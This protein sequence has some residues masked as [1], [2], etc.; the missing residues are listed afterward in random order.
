[1]FGLTLVAAAF[2]FTALLA[3]AYHFRRTVLDAAEERTGLTRRS[4]HR[5]RKTGE[6]WMQMAVQW[7]WLSKDG[8]LDTLRWRC[9]LVL[10]S[11]VAGLYALSVAIFVLPATSFAAM[12]LQA[13]PGLGLGIAF[14]RAIVLMV[15]AVVLIAT[16]L[17]ALHPTRLWIASRGAHAGSEPGGTPSGAT[18]PLRRRILADYPAVAATAGVLALAAMLV[19]HW[20]SLSP[21]QRLLFY[22]RAADLG[23]GLSPMMPLA[24]AAST[25]V[26]W[27]ICE[28][29]RLHLTDDLAIVA[30]GNA[31]GRPCEEGER[32]TA[33]ATP[34]GRQEGSPDALVAF[35]DVG[36]SSLRSIA[37]LEGHIRRAMTDR[38]ACLPMSVTL[39]A[40]AAFLFAMVRV[41][42]HAPWSID[43]RAFDHLWWLAFATGYFVL[44]ATFLRA[45][46]VLTYLRRMLRHLTYHPI[47]S[48]FAELQRSQGRSL[49]VDPARSRGTT[50]VLAL[51][52]EQAARTAA[53]L[54]VRTFERKRLAE[55]VDRA[56]SA[57]DNAL[58][59]EA[60]R[61]WARVGEWRR[62][63]HFHMSAATT[64]AADLLDRYQWRAALPQRAAAAATGT[65]GSAPPPSDAI[66]S[67]WTRHAEL[68]LAS[69]IAD[70]LNH[71]MAL[72]RHLSI[73]VTFGLM[74][75]LLATASYP[76]QPRDLLLALNWSIIGTVVVVSLVAIILLGRDPILTDLAGTQQ[77]L[78]N[79]DVMIKVFIY[80]A[81][82]I[83]SLL[84]VQ[85]PEMF[86]RIMPWLTSLAGGN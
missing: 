38:L 37:A 14:A 58:A 36:G 5:I 69:R 64:I 53:A 48:S 61:K 6:S 75:M 51:T 67:E 77:S 68:V 83:L 82:P 74:L 40:G 52:I 18:L 24:L 63:A 57:L 78:F 50:S 59:A 32:Q 13:T 70:F 44:L 29:R 35:L 30:G 12:S 27:A 42:T 26:L 54:P 20:Y 17:V 16:A 22:V 21:E 41:Y 28:W 56:T 79:R 62:Q 43:G 33:G 81:L 85:F 2:A 80:G 47:R 9:V 60:N 31:A 3:C 66:G 25:A 55:E 23:S 71:V 84:G 76:F 19:W 72:L 8:H 11:T 86:N 73:F 46:C 39:T 65:G 15:L 1:M 7:L 34:D 45:V 4:L 49:R 10:L